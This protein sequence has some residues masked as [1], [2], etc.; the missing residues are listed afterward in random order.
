MYKQKCYWTEVI[1]R[2][3]YIPPHITSTQHYSSKEKICQTYSTLTFPEL[4]LTTHTFHE[5][6][7][8]W[9]ASTKPPA[10]FLMR[11]CT[12]LKFRNIN[13]IDHPINIIT[14]QIMDNKQIV[15]TFI[16]L[17]YLKV[18]TRNDF[19]STRIHIF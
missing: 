16:L 19:I 12:D 17:A 8:F 1:Y 18:Y 15:V 5:V 7:R 6:C 4:L 13:A 2:W 14:V 9:I 11:A 10:T 3:T